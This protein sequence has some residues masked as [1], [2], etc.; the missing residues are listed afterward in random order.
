MDRRVTPPKRVT[1]T[2]WDP[3]PPCKQALTT[4]LL[5][6]RKKQMSPW[7]LNVGN[8]VEVKSGNSLEVRRSLQNKTQATW[9]LLPPRS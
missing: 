5:R 7:G 4:T 2:T 3:P 8:T 9:H 6:A 1:S